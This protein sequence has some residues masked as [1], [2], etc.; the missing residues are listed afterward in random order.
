MIEA[1]LY[2]AKA[3]A[4][5]AAL[6]PLN[7]KE[8]TKIDKRRLTLHKEYIKTREKIVQIDAST[9]NQN[10]LKS[11]SSSVKTK[12]II[13]SWLSTTSIRSTRSKK[14]SIEVYTTPGEAARHD[15][16]TP[17][18]RKTPSANPCTMKWATTWFSQRCSKRVFRC[19]WLIRPTRPKTT[20]LRM[21]T[22]QTKGT[23][24]SKKWTILEKIEKSGTRKK[25]ELTQRL[26][27]LLQPPE[28]IQLKEMLLREA[29]MMP[30]KD[31]K[32]ELNREE[33]FNEFTKAFKHF[34]PDVI[35]NK[36]DTITPIN[37]S[38]KSQFKFD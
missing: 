29:V 4:D 21:D 20:A 33:Y 7:S 38:L 27:L 13:L 8:Q 24:E 12:D 34:N 6:V 9:S 31:Q 15:S 17:V 23:F 16:L 26:E 2:N 35:I 36:L 37:F 3:R 25:V 30:A 19:C 28:K 32:C 14:F 18:V 10:T 1:V 5:F 11:S 22:S